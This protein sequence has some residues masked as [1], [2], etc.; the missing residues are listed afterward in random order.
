[1]LARPCQ[2][3]LQCHYSHPFLSISN[4]ARSVYRRSGICQAPS[5]IVR[6]VCCDREASSSVTSTQQGSTLM[7]R[8]FILRLFDSYF[9][10][11][12]LNLLPLVLMLSMGGAYFQ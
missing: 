1:M 4:R 10:H 2:I 9:R 11:R 5:Y 8:L 3:A 7:A 12:W 6:S